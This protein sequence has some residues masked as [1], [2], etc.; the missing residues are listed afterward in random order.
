MNFLFHMLDFACKNS[1]WFFFMLFFYLLF[2]IIMFIF[3][4]KS[5]NIMSI[6]IMAFLKILFANS[7][8]SVI[9]VSASTDLI[10]FSG[11]KSHY[12]YQEVKFP[13]D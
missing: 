7:V 10:F 12:L 11:F 1:M 3:S 13:K 2:F 5:L 6:F 8:I 9:S 4:F